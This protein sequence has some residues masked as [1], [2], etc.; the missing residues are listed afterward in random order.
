MRIFFFAII[1]GALAAVVYDIFT[2]V[3]KL[4]KHKKTALYVF[5]LLF[6]ILCFVSS[7]MFLFIEGQ[8][9]IEGYVLFGAV[10]GAL[11]YFGG[12]SNLL[13]HFLTKIH[14]KRQNK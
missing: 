6:C 14:Q 9:Q 8:G 7:V 10:L 2:H 11:A 12:F 1:F 5:D 3:A 4:L 13:R